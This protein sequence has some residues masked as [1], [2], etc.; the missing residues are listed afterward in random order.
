MSYKIGKY[1]KNVKI[2]Y[3][4]S[5]RISLNITYPIKIRIIDTCEF[6]VDLSFNRHSKFKVVIFKKLM[7]KN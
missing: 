4:F 5:N 3:K 6:S 2:S 1:S 7:R